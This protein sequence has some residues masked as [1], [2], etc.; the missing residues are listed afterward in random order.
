MPSWRTAHNRA[1][2]NRLRS[3]YLEAREFH[4]QRVARLYLSGRTDKLKTSAFV[5]RPAKRALSRRPLPTCVATR[6]AP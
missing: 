1:R 4:E 3:V 2:R 5:R 6:R